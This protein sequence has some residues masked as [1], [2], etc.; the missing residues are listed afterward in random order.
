MGSSPRQFLD[1]TIVTGGDEGLQEQLGA[2]AWCERPRN[3]NADLEGLVD[4][5]TEDESVVLFV[6]IA[7]DMLDPLGIAS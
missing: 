4:Q 3:A 1:P 2:Q 5:L 6:T 7:V